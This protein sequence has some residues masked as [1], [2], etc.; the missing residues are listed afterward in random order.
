MRDRVEYGI[1]ASC[2]CIGISRHAFR[3]PLAGS[4]EPIGGPGGGKGGGG[5]GGGG[6]GETALGYGLEASC[7]C[8]G[9]SRIASRVP[10]EGSFGATRGLVRSLW[11]SFGGLRGASWGPPGP[12]WRL[13][14]GLWRPLGAFLGP[15]RGSWGRKGSFFNFGSPSWTP[16]GAVLEPSWAV[17]GTS[18]A[19]LGP[20]WAVLGP[21]WGPLGP[22]RSGFEGLWGRLGA[23]G[24]RKGDKTK[25]TVKHN[26]K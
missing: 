16:L 6:H 14:G 2:R 15:P 17:L 7:V 9:I 21:S 13:P 18:W 12:S 25:N 10:L 5:G 26:G 20:S 11:E 22:F 1:E 8:I 23:S 24:S 3:G 4:L 19:V